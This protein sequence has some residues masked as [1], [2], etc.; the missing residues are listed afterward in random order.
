MTGPRVAFGADDHRRYGRHFVLPEV[1]AEG[2]ARLAASSVLL[3]GAGGLGSPAALYLAAAGVGRLGL[4]D[5]DTVDLSNL[6]RQVLFGTRDV[7]RPK[8]EAAAERLGDLNPGVRIE[9]HPTRLD[10]SNALD[11]IARYDVVLDGS[12]NF[13]TRYLVNDACALAGK[14]DV[15]GSV[16]RFEGQVSVFDAASG[17]CYRCLYP[18]PPAPGTVPNCAEGGV[19]GVLPG[20]V[21]AIQAVE[22]IKILLGRGRTLSGRLL[23]FDALT[24]RFDELRLSRDP[25]CPLCGESPTIRDLSEVAATCAVPAPPRMPSAVDP[26]SLR[27]RLDAGEPLV[28][29]DVRSAGEFALARLPG[30]LCIPV[31]E[32]GARVGEL[33][34]GATVVVYCHRGIRSV[35]GVEILRRAGFSR[36]EHLDGGID[37]WAVAVDPEV[38][39][40]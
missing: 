28:L 36:V 2:Q 21:G 23:L 27:R 5:F 35:Q 38:P 4:V 7:G 20:I 32:L 37:A 1:G 25:R 8:L 14:A 19:L 30:A 22:A 10:P 6:Q 33:D 11:R 34:A 16:F 15:F 39:R 29:L 18:E 24:M 9:L 31:H 40:Y 17:P 13:P 3:I 12:D 26:A